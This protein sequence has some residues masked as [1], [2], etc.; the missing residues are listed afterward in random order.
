MAKILAF[1]RPCYKKNSEQKLYA[2][3][4][5]A[6]AFCHVDHFGSKVHPHGDECFWDPLGGPLSYLMAAKYLI[7]VIKGQGIHCK[8]FQG[9]SLKR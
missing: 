6:P 1:F 5:S 2:N 9:S 4:K 7:T 3:N 8:C